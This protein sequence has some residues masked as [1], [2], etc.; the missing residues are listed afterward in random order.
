M[1]DIKDDL[2]NSYLRVESCILISVVIIFIFFSALKF[3]LLSKY[4]VVT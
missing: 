2:T 3:N 4:K 1:L